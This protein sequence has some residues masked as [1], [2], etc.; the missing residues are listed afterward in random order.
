MKKKLQKLMVGLLVCG[1]LAAV[2]PIPA[3]AAQ[4]SDVPASHWAASSITRAVQAGLIQGE[5]PTTFGLGRDMTR[6][7]F[8]AALCRLFGWEL[9]TPAQGTFADNQDRNAWYYSAV[10][11]AYAHGAVTKQ[12]RAF[13]PYDAITREEMAVML[14]RALRYTTLA[15]LEQG[16]SCPFRDVDSNAGYL[17][18]AYH[19]GISGGT[20]AATFSPDGK[21]TREQAVVM[22][23]RVHDRCASKTPERI[24]IVRSG[25]GLSFMSGY[26]TVAVAAAQLSD[27]G[28]VQ[29]IPTMGSGQ[30]SAIRTAAKSDGAKTLLYLTGGAAA[31]RGDPA[32]T[33][34]SIASAAENGGWD[35][36]LLDLPD[37]PQEQ[38]SAETALV[39]ALHTALG[40][41][42]LY[43]AAEAPS[44][45]GAVYGYDYAA[46]AR[47]ADRVILRVAPYTQEVKGFPLAPL[48]PLEEVYYALAS[49][50]RSGVGG[51]KLSL[52]LTSTGS[53]W[54]GTTNTGTVSAQDI[55]A[56]LNTNQTSAYYS[57]RYECAYL[58]RTVGGTRTVVWYQDETAA[59]ARVQL[60]AFFGVDSV[61]L[62]DLSSAADITV[63]PCSMN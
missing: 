29:V 49:L 10:E 23:M 15:G 3:A 6:A 54:T 60:C 34:S 41:S 4:F 38:A 22:L 62:S 2:L 11:T 39:S 12:D 17:T 28:A 61:C 45:N 9:E 7:A 30:A 40:S 53:V 5:T 26:G 59:G 36:V 44:S 43:V 47:Q 51:S 63:A 55:E 31:L 46:L 14:V 37:L 50:K 16:L 42:L 52:W 1:V 58:T 24:G 35:G 21:G 20:S 33:A 32:D 8:T 18:L 19:L 48:E 13:R 27:T 25:D 56:L 57:A